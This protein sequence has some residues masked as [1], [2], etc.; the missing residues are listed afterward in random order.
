MRFLPVLLLVAV[1]VYAAID[2]LR[3]P[4]AEIKHV[5]KAVWLLAILVVWLVG[6]VLWLLTGRSRG[7]QGPV[8]RPRPVAPDDDP[9]FLRQLNRQRALQEREAELRR[10]EEELR[11]R[12]GDAGAERRSEQDGDTV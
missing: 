9:E 12:E 11:R 4:D 7:P 3:T 8:A 10:R 1:T 5:P 2:C 6:P